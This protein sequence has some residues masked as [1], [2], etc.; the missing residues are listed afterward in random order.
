M[1]SRKLAAAVLL[2]FAPAVAQ[3]PLPTLRIEP[4][5]GGSVFY[6]RNTASQPLT[7]YLI[8]LVDYPGS[9]FWLCQDDII[10]EPIAP[11]AERR[12]PITNMTVGAVPD[13]V[14][15][16]AALFA[17]GSSAGSTEK[18]ALLVDARRTTLETARELIRRVEQA[19]SSGMSK[20]ELVTGLRAYF[21]TLAPQR[22]KA[23]EAIRR[24]TARNLISTT[25]TGLNAAPFDKVLA[26]LRAAEV[27]L[28]A[29][30]PGLQQ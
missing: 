12:T 29:S 28:A 27:R 24:G 26:T 15:M 21:T 8:E 17:D 11:G 23:Q 22:G 1:S 14:K 19:Q 3:S 7:A 6:I 2:A 13:Y 4:T 25:A 30:K 9:S 5:A 16:T 18:V 20:D 10:A